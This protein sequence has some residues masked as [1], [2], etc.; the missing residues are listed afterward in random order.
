MPQRFE[1][2]IFSREANKVMH[3]AFEAAWRAPSTHLSNERLILY[4]VGRAASMIGCLHEICA[5][6]RGNRNEPESYQRAYGS[7]WG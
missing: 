2:K 7:D 5:W 1:S 3:E 4:C 6:Q